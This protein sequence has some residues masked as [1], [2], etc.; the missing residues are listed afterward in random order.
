MSSGCQIPEAA[1]AENVQIM[2]D[3]ARNYPLWSND[4]FRTIAQLREVYFTEGSQAFTA[5]CEQE[6]VSAAVET[7][8]REVIQDRLDALAE[9]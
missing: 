8:A 4:E 5:A 6:T 1:P 9:Q 2:I 3:K 7:A